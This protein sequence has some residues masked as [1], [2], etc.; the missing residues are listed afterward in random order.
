VWA[1]DKL[2]NPEKTIEHWQNSFIHIHVKIGKGAALKSPRILS[3]SIFD[4]G[5]S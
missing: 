4:L 3:A 1:I 2:L 5:N